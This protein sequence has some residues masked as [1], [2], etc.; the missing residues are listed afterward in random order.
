MR[1]IKQIIILVLSLMTITAVLPQAAF[2]QA[3]LGG[4]NLNEGSGQTINDI[5]GNGNDGQLGSTVNPDVDDPTWTTGIS[6]NALYFDG[7][8]DRIIIDDSPTMRP[9]QLTIEAWARIDNNGILVSK[10]Y[11]GAYDNSYVLYKH[12]TGK[13]YAYVSTTAGG[14]TIE[15]PQAPTAG[16]F[17][18]AAMTWDGEFLKLYLD[19]TPVATSP[20]IPATINYDASPVYMGIDRD[21]SNYIFPLQGIIDDVTMWDRALDASEIKIRYGPGE[22]HPPVHELT[23][24]LFIIVGLLALII[25]ITY[26]RQHLTI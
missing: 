15:A 21:F 3:V 19:G 9:Q 25:Y 10:P 16:V 23:T 20:S 6:T 22:P 2:A 18:H 7:I 13:F 24:I 5:S 14:I 12:P 4:W 8:D 11:G 1:R 26:R 17:F